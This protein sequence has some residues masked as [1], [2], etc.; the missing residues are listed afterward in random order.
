MVTAVEKQ[1]KNSELL[2]QLSRK[3]LDELEIEYIEILK[4]IIL[5]I[6]N[7]HNVDLKKGKTNKSVRFRTAILL[8]CKELDLDKLDCEELCQRKFKYEHMLND[9]IDTHKSYYH[10]VKYYNEIVESIKNNLL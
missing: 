8:V 1:R 4:S 10:T 5:P 3:F 2:K 9:Y 6:I 7:R